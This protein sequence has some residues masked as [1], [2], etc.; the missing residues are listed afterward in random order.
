MRSKS[1]IFLV[2]PYIIY[3]GFDHS[4]N[5]SSVRHLSWQAYHALPFFCTMVC[6]GQNLKKHQSSLP[7]FAYGLLQQPRS[8]LVPYD[9]GLRT[10]DHSGSIKCPSGFPSSMPLKAPQGSR[11]KGCKWRSLS[12]CPSVLLIPP[13][14]RA[15]F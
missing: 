15:N 13:R 6:S 1:D 7:G 12:C 2:V 10:L 9:C 4:K 8:T 11:C 5:S 3:S 14:H